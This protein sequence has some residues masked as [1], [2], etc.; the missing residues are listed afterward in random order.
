VKLRAAVLVLAGCAAHGSG[1]TAGSGGAPGSAV[2][3]G[4]G[5][6]VATF[7]LPLT[8]T[9]LVTAVVDDW[10]STHA[11]L[12]LWHRT[13]PTWTR[14]AAWSGVIG[15]SGAAWGT[16][17]HGGALGEGPVKHEGDGKSP[18]GAFALRGVYGYAASATTKM[19]YTPTDP[20][21]ECVDDAASHEYTKIVRRDQV[22]VDWKS[23]EQ[24]RRP[25]ELYTWVVDV[26]HNADAHPGGG[27]CIFLHV[28]SGPDS[29]T[30]GCTAMPEPDLAKLVGVL[31]PAAHPVF[32]LL[33]RAEYARVATA[34]GLPALR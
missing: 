29:S 28:W 30:S 14:D 8:T 27:S 12:A 11:T 21:W 13:G 24:M 6:A 25:D 1:G 19:P 18:A 16:G 31:D 2:G 34:W 9:Q 33:P 5:S 4:S 10:T 22:S 20:R 7:S 26:A 3:V 15:R 17:L 23:S 32:V